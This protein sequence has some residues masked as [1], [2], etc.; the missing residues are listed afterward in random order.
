MFFFHSHCLTALE[1]RPCTKDKLFS[2]KPTK[3]SLPHTNQSLSLV[4]FYFTW[5]DALIR[6][7]IKWATLYHCL[8]P[9]AMRSLPSAIST[10]EFP[11]LFFIFWPVLLLSHFDNT[12]CP[13]DTYFITSNL[14]A[15][16]WKMICH[17]P[18]T[19]LLRVQVVTVW[20]LCHLHKINLNKAVPLKC[21]FSAIMQHF[22]RSLPL[23]ITHFLLFKLRV[24]CQN[25]LGVLLD[26]L[27]IE[28]IR[29]L[30]ASCFAW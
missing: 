9:D 30:A 14:S 23:F 15:F 2:F 8:L 19:F 10:L 16:L 7:R 28:I 5:L 1:K 13:S 12:D 17:F 20:A 24:Y 27:V 18:N 11:S 6:G 3:M 29:E 25:A 22:Y 26:T 21:T 4:L